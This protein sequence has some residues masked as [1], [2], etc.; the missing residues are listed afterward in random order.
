MYEKIE[1]SSHD[2]EQALDQMITV[3]LDTVI[4]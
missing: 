4:E 1:L 3:A 2:R